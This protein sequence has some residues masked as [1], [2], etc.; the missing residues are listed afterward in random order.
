MSSL[1][2]ILSSYAG[3]SLIIILILALKLNLKLS[4]KKRI[5]SDREYMEELVHELEN[6]K[7]EIFKLKCDCRDLQSVINIYEIAESQKAIEQIKQA[8]AEEKDISAQML[9]KLIENGYICVAEA[10]K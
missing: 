9:E 5:V 7:E 8:L 1:L 10:F 2:I 4:D 6:K 3:V